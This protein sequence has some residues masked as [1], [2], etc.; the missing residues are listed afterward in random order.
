MSRVEDIFEVIDI[1][2]DICYAIKSSEY[3]TES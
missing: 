3:D 2:F 1:L